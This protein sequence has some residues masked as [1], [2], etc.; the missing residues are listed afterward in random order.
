MN[1]KI[2]ITTILV[3]LVSVGFSQS[4]DKRIWLSGY[5]RSTIYMDQLTSETPDSVTSPNTNYGHTLI[6]L[7]ANIKPN[8]Q[9]FIKS[10]VRIRNEYGGFW[11]SGITFDL[12]ELYVKGIIAN[13]IRYQLGD[14]NY[15]LTPFTFFNNN[16]EMYSNTPDIFKMYSDMVHYD[17]FYND[18]NTWRQQ[19]VAADFSLSFKK[20]ADEMQFNLFSTRVK[21]TDF[22]NTDDKIFAGGNITLVQSK[23]VSAGVNYVNLFEIPGTSNDTLYEKNQVLTGTYKLSFSTDELSFELNGESGLSKALVT[24]S[25][26]APVTEDFFNYAK[27]EAKYKP[28]NVCFGLA[29]RN[30][31]PNFRS[32][33]AQMRRLNYGVYA[34]AYERYSND[35]ILRPVGIWDIYNEEVLFN[36]QINNSLDEFYPQYDNI[37]PYGI[38]TPNRKGFDIS[39]SQKNPSEIYSIE[40]NYQ[41]LTEVVGQGTELLRKFQSVSVDAQLNIDKFFDSFDRKIMINGGFKYDQT[42]RSGGQTFEDVNLN[43]QCINIGLTVEVFKDFEILAGYMKYNAKGNEQI[44]ERDQYNEVVYF[45]PFVTNL[46]EDMMGFGLRY[47][48]SEKTNL[49]A[50]WQ[51]YTWDDTELT[52]PDYGFNRIAVVYRMKF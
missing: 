37:E 38:S 18:N 39:L 24:N 27:F 44:A 5:A 8:D 41:Y 6:D 46:N 26:E 7:S 29:Y 20:F 2:L 30:V 51:K 28:L 14:I 16:E 45:N 31:G 49:Q 12:R 23:Y 52:Q 1:R 33:G 32:P 21:T 9:T 48:F 35:Q 13:A 22:A 34:N 10:T 42:T 17:L 4:T 15:K 3:L 43:S 11:G 50:V 36:T 47:N 25:T 40:A 19:G